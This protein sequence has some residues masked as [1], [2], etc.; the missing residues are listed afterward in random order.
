MFFPN[1]PSP[2]QLAAIREELGLNKPFVSRYLDWMLGLLRGDFGESYK[3]SRP[4]ID[5]LA[6]NIP[7]TVELAIAGMILS[8]LIGIPSGVLAGISRSKM[9]DQVVMVVALIGVSAPSFWLGLLLMLVFSLY[10]G[11]LPSFGVGGM[12][13]L[14]LP[15]ITLGLYGGGYL[16]RF[17]R[18]SIMEAKHLGHVP[19]ARAKGLS[20]WTVLTRHITRNALIPIVTMSGILGGY[21]LGGAVIVETVFARAGVGH[22]L[23][24]AISDKDYPLVQG[25]LFFTIS[26]FI[27]MN[28]LVDL[29]YVYLDPRVRLE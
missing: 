1:V 3:Q 9:I 28:L 11:W 23:V 20:E 24:R 21:M 29:S 14:V 6:Q 22:M 12:A 8:L 2:E 7:P 19:T 10:L 25:L 13:K 16:A 5:I 18:S 4:V 15:A 26:V 17:A 27:L